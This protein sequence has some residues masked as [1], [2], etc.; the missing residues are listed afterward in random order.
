MDNFII[1]HSHAAQKEAD[2]D[3]LVSR[4]EYRERYDDKSRKIKNVLI[5]SFLYQYNQS[6][7]Q[8]KNSTTY[9]AWR[10]ATKKLVIKAGEAAVCADMW[11]KLPKPDLLEGVYFILIFR[12]IHLIL[13]SKIYW[14][15]FQ[16]PKH[17]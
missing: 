13:R 7:R 10:A 17:T 2:R 14:S 4:G 9:R 6:S 11:M 15:K 8:D 12:P 5:T 1:L 3:A 16:T